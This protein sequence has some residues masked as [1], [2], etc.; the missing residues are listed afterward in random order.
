MHEKGGNQLIVLV[1]STLLASNSEYIYMDRKRNE[2]Q[3]QLKKFLCL[4]IPR[5]TKRIDFWFHT[6]AQN[7]NIVSHPSYTIP[8]QMAAK[9][10]CVYCCMWFATNAIETVVTFATIATKN[11][12]IRWYIASLSIRPQASARILMTNNTTKYVIK[13]NNFTKQFISGKHS[14]LSWRREQTASTVYGCVCMRIDRF[15]RFIHIYFALYLLY[16]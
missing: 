15:H 12:L 8:P 2:K 3:Q 5:Q 9:R 4:L 1:G 11:Q 14:H 16:A 6:N 10:I 7:R 13:N